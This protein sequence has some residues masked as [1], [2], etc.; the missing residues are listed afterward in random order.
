MQNSVGSNWSCF[1]I[2]ELMTNTWKNTW[3][4]IRP[5]T[6][7]CTFK[8]S[9][10]LVLNTDT[11]ILLYWYW[12]LGTPDTDTGTVCWYC[13]WHCT[14]VVILTLIL[15]WQNVA[16]E[17]H[18]CKTKFETCVDICWFSMCLNGLGIGETCSFQV[19]CDDIAN[20]IPYFVLSQ[21]V[22]RHGFF[23]GVHGLFAPIAHALNPP[24]GVEV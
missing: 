4:S 17:S 11:G 22:F 6:R 2:C 24:L 3:Q 8:I 19:F 12:I 15:C 20:T 21:V 9:R 1:W 7:Y 14:D 10:L 23:Y 5:G 18:S 16:I 13:Y